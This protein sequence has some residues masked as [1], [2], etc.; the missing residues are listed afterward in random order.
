MGAWSGAAAWGARPESSALEQHMEW[1]RP[2][3]A[4]RGVPRR[5]GSPRVK[6]AKWP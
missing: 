6:G 1:A 3:A 4:W 5:R 2:G